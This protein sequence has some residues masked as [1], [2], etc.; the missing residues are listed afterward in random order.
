MSVTPIQPKSLATAPADVA[1]R[2]KNILGT[3]EGVMS[4]DQLVREVKSGIVISAPMEAVFESQNLRT[5]KI[6]ANEYVG[7]VAANTL[8]FG[9]WT[10][11]AAGAAALLAPLGLPAFAVGVA[12]FAAGMLAN[13]LWDRTFGQAIV[14]I[15]KE[16]L[17]DAQARPAAEAFV[18]YV[19]NPLHD[20][21]WKPVSGFVGD[22]KVLAGVLLGAAALRFPG[23]ARAVGREAGKMALGTAAALGVQATVVDRVLAPAAHRE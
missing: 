22:H 21:L 14:S 5:G 9:T 17:T 12:G 19:A 23:A 18:K 11:G 1:Q 8:G 4:R 10:L 20:Y 7:R 2:A 15:A 13:D 3:A 16:R 6:Q